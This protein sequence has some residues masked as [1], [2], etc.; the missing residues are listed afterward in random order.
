MS[1]VLSL[2]VA[3]L[4]MVLEATCRLAVP[5][6][7]RIEHRVVEERNAILAAGRPPVSGLQVIVLGNSLLEAGIHFDEA[8]RLLSP[9]INPRRWVVHDTGYLD[10]YYGLRRLLAEGSRPD[11]VILVLTPSQ[12]AVWGIRGSYF[13]YRMMRMADLFS[14]ARDVG[15]SNTETSN[16]AFANLSAF[17]GLG[18]E[19][20]KWFLSR[21]FQDLPELTKLMTAARSTRLVEQPFDSVCLQR[22]VALRQLTAQYGASF[23][24]VIPPNG[25]EAECAA[26]QR[27]GSFAGVSVL[28]PVPSK[29]LPS[30]YYSDGFHLN[31]RGAKVFTRSFVEAIQTWSLTISCG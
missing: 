1:L 21:V 14:V 16:L 2:I 17:F 19:V 28:V 26:V 30:D 24:L 23:V 31:D 10:W 15:L 12:M 18:A 6:L 8:R 9:D 27:A 4:S 13:G 5:R 11:V 22:L 25:T 20:R 7:S 3:L 29:S